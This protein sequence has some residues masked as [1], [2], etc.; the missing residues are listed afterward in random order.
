[1]EIGFSDKN[2]IW[3]AYFLDIEKSFAKIDFLFRVPTT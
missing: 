3:K 1:M 2:Q